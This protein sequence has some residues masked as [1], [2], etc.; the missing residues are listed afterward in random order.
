[1]DMFDTHMLGVWGLMAVYAGTIMEGESVLVLAIMLVDTGVFS[2]QGVM[3]AGY[4]GAVT[5]DLFCF[6]MGR[7]HGRY[8]C[9]QWP[10]QGKRIMQVVAL[11]E[12]HCLVVTMGYRFVYGL[13]S[14]VPAALGMGSMTTVFF[15]LLDLCM[16]LVWTLAVTLLGHVVVSTTGKVH[17]WARYQLVALGLVLLGILCWIMGRYA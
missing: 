8:L 15:V 2:L 4:L 14:V 9:A 10:R 1:M 7:R 11:L 13:R 16:A 3:V 12:D 17:G 5:G 6:W